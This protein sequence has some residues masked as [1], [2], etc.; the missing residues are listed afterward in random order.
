METPYVATFISNKL[1]YHLFL[2]SSTKLENR[3]VGQFLCGEEKGVSTG[4]RGR[5]QGKGV[6]G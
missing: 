1:K 4:G 6:G 3:R 2:F 5:K